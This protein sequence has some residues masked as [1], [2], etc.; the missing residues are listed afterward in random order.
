MKLS[1]SKFKR[2]NV[3]LKLAK[4]DKLSND[5]FECNCLK[6]EEINNVK[7]YSC[8]DFNGCSD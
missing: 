8:S 3:I 4:K 6:C 2:K 1:K 7:Y 5:C